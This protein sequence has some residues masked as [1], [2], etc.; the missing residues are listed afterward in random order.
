MN[1]NLSIDMGHVILLITAIG[2]AIAFF[3]RRK[4]ESKDLMRRKRIEVY[5][6][7]MQAHKS[8][9]PKGLIDFSYRENENYEARYSLY[10]RFEK[11]IV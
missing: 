4:Y 1:F 11:R 2:G 6:S 3:L 9:R 5:H 10:Q 8:F 7:F